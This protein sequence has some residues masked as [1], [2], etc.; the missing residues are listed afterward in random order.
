[1]HRFVGTVF[2]VIGLSVI[3]MLIMDLVLIVSDTVTVNNRI[4]ALSLVI[5]DELSRHNAVHGDIG[6]MFDKQLKEI[7]ENSNIAKDV[8][9]NWNDIVTING[10]SYGPI[11]ENHARNYGDIIDLVITVEME[12]KFFMILGTSSQQSGGKFLGRGTFSYTREYH[13]KVPALRYLK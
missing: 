2:K 5:Q 13:Y 6:P 10:V 12:P 8:K 7:V 1:M 9:W 3:M 4:E 11:N